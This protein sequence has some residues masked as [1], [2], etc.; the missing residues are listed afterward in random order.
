MTDKPSLDVKALRLT[1]RRDWEKATR[2][3]MRFTDR[4]GESIPWW[5][6]IVAGV[7]FL[8]SIP[9][10]IDVFNI[11]TPRVGYV[12]PFGV[13]FGLLYAAFRRRQLHRVSWQLLTLELLLFVTSVIVNGAG[14]LQAVIAAT[15]DVQG[16]SFEVLIGDYRALPV[17]SQVALLL[18]PVAALIIPIGTTVAGDGLASLFLEGRGSGNWLEARWKDEQGMV[19]FEALRDAALQ[20]GYTPTQ[21]A[22]WAEQIAYAGAASTTVH[23]WTRPQLSMPAES[24]QSVDEF[25]EQTGQRGQFGNSSSGYT[26]QMD[27]RSV[28]RAYLARH[29]E[30]RTASLNQ[31]VD[32]IRQETGVKVGRSSVHNVLHEPVAF[33][34]NGHE[35]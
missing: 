28:I 8:L 30:M 23:A 9:H 26:K 3:R 35:R 24:E 10:T 4:A 15:S 21:A 22:R 20:A 5:L 25:N 7:F 19:E 18:V 12:A 14:S 33:S 29:P 16:K 2:Q 34:D 13:E 32:N 1:A 17:I 6:I 11:I 27:A 31:I